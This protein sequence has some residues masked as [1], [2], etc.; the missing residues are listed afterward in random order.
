MLGATRRATVLQIKNLGMHFPQKAGL[1]FGE[2][3]SSDYSLF[4]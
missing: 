2:V 3:L 1:P 4:P